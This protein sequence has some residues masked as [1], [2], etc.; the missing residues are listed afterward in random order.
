MRTFF[1]TGLRATL[2]AVVIAALGGGARDSIAEERGFSVR[3]SVEMVTFS[4][5]SADDA[6]GETRLSPDGKHIA[7]VTSRGRIASDETESVLSLFDTKALRTFLRAPGIPAPHPVAIASLAAV[8]R[9]QRVASYPAVITAL[10]WALDSRS[11]YFLGEHSDAQ[12][13]LYQVDVSGNTM[14]ALTPAGYDVNAFDVVGNTIVYRA[15]NVAFSLALKDSLVKGAPINM[16]ARA[17]TGIP[18]VHI[19][20]PRE[21]LSFFR[22]LD[23]GYIRDGVV[24]PVAGPEVGRFQ[25]LLGSS[26]ESRVLSLAPDAH[27]VIELSLVDHISPAWV[28]NY[29]WSSKALR[30]THSAELKNDGMG[31]DPTRNYVQVDFEAGKEAPLIDAPQDRAFSYMDKPMAVWSH[32]GRLVLV[33]GTF[34]PLEGVSAVERGRRR[35]PCYA[36]LVDVRSRSVSCVSFSAYRADD[37]DSATTKKVLK[38]AAFGA[39]DQEVKLAFVRSDGSGT[40]EIYRF[41]RGRWALATSSAADVES[42]PPRGLAVSVKQDLDTPPTLWVADP[43]SGASKELW[44]PNP[45]LAE[46]KLGK[47]SVYHWTDATGHLWT[48]GLILPVGYVAGQRYPLVI[49]TYAFPFHKFLADGMDTTAEAA[50]PLASAGMVVLQIQKRFDVSATDQE[51]AVQLPGFTAAIERLSASGVVDRQRVGIIGF[52]RG[53]YYVESALIKLTGMFAAATVADGADQSYMLHRIDYDGALARQDDSIYG[54]KPDGPGL[55]KWLAEAPGFNLDRVRTPLRI[56]AIGPES[57]LAEWELYAS[58]R[59]QGKPVDLIYLPDGQHILQKPLE[60][61]ASQQG[62]VDWFR[63]WLQGVEDTGAGKSEQYRRWEQLCSLQMAGNPN[64]Q[65]FC[66]PS[67]P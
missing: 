64:R 6:E 41:K 24:R 57:V 9:I 4:A 26:F 55:Q 17:L 56:E 15:E 66:V 11:I 47:A 30:V 31:N 32:S 37:P 27:S 35:H 1:A 43:V 25:H 58:L 13:Q 44:D 42:K 18:L 19:L 60:R 61:M 23:L 36:A 14:H 21:S 67:R 7:V 34:L 5:P 46:R 40:T 28:S 53:C 16:D 59:E 45:Q 20:F 8:T 3:D 49:Q 33:T 12:R 63:F 10:R 29:E 2:V 52:S 39:T 51:A 48:G 22:A 65:S 38:D 62:N 50:M 54:V